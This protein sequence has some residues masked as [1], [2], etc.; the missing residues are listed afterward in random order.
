MCD[1][2]TDEALGKFK[3]AYPGEKITKKDLFYY[4]YGLLHSE[5]YRQRYANN[6]TKQLPRIPVVKQFADFRA[7][8][9]AGETLAKLH[10]GFDTVKLYPAKIEYAKARSALTD[11]DY[12]VTKM[13]FGKPQAVNGGD[14]ANP[15]EKWDRTTIHYNEG[16]TVRDIPLEAYDYIVNGKSAIEWVVE[17]Q[18]VTTDKATGIVNDA[19]AWA[20]EQGNAKYPLDLLLRVITVSLET[21]KIVRALP[22][23]KV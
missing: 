22:A 6:L 9:E 10:L 13:R 15:D 19:N 16:V 23:L 3:V 21:M 8:V 18:A 1:A 5:D 2:I 14:E 17:R 11:E 20:A 12:R 4:V 7:F